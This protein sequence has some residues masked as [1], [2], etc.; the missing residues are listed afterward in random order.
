MKKLKIEQIEI[1][2]GTQT[3]VQLHDTTVEDYAEAMTAGKKFPPV[4]VFY[5]GTHFFLADGFHRLMAAALNGWKEIESDIRKGGRVDALKHSLGANTGHGL[6]RTGPDKRR[7]VEIALK[8]FPKLSARAVAEMCGVS[9][10]F[11]LEIKKVE[12]LT[13]STSTPKSS[14]KTGFSPPAPPK[15]VVGQDGKNYPEKRTPAPAKDPNGKVIPSGLLGLWNRGQEIQAMMTDLSQ[16][17]TAIERAQDSKDA[18]YAEI[19]YSHVIAGLESMRTAIA[20]T[21]PYCL[22][23]ICHGE[24]CRSCAGRGL[25]GKFRYDT[26]VP[27]EMKK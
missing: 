21:K 10:P 9:D 17:K 8:E 24:G 6:R 3:R 19:N 16:M 14:E 5:D 20:A 23:P 22:C 11:V 27:K 7:C 1:D 18:L 25:I 2:A 12:V 26:C 13:V 15:T 4:V